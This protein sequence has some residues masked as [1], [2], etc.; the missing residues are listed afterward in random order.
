MQQQSMHLHTAVLLLDGFL[1]TSLAAFVDTLDSVTE[2]FGEDACSTRLMTPT[3]R[4]AR[5]E[6]DAEIPVAH[7]L[8]WPADLGYVVVLGRITERL[9]RWSNTVSR[10]LRTADRLDVTIV[11]IE[12]GIE[13]VARVGLLDGHAACARPAEREGLQQ[14]F[15]E[16]DFSSSTIV[17]RDRR[18]MTSLG[19]VAA[20]DLA[21][22]L[23]TSHFSAAEAHRAVTRLNR[24]GARAPE[25]PAPPSVPAVRYADPRVRRA[26]VMME[27]SIERPR[28]I[29]DIARDVGLSRRQFERLFRAEAGRSAK[30]V[31][32]TIRLEHARRLLA[33][34]NISVAAVASATGFA[35][36][37]HLS[38]TMRQVYQRSPSDLRGRRPNPVRPSD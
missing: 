12:S 6:T 9:W 38:K 29:D 35:D 20:S 10:Y 13:A 14:R 27:L 18:R 28:A 15:P 19:G 32:L 2:A 26:V 30:T 5:T 16:V 1:L 21:A 3:G 8:I 4:P 37:A 33:Q 25:T 24:E 23:I 31:Y 36:G 22:S 17:V 34:E 11:A 7:S